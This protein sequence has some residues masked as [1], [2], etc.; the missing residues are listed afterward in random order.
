MFT[1]GEDVDL[2]QVP[3]NV[4]GVGPLT[5]NSNQYQDSAFMA[6]WTGNWQ[7]TASAAACA[8]LI[9]TEGVSTVRPVT[10]DTY[11]AKSSQGNIA[12]FVVERIN[13]DSTGAMTS[14][15]VEATVWTMSS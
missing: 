9:S 14:T 8:E 11:C 2:D 3:P 12:I 6:S 7:G 10:G 5:L 1:A 4:N 13:V 15:L